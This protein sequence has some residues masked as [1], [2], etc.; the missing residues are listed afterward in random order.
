M[1]IPELQRVVDDWIKTVGKGY[2]GVLTNM[3]LLIEEVGELARLLARHYGEQT[4]KPGEDSSKEALAEEFAD[5]LFVLVCLANQTHVDLNQAFQQKL[6]KKTERDRE[7][8][9]QRSNQHNS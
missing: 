2:Y 5:I 8:H 4:F 1:S 9:L 7:R 6:R 3:A